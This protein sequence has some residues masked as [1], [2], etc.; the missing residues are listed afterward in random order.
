MGQDFMR[1]MAESPKHQSM[2]TPAT[3]NCTLPKFWKYRFYFAIKCN[4]N[5]AIVATVHLF[6]IS[7]VQESW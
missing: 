1:F 2:E 7:E 5:A 6:F 4:G 3:Q